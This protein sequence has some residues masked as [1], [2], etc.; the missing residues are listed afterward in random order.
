MHNTNVLLTITSMKRS[1]TAILVIVI[2]GVCLLCAGCTT[3]NTPAEVQDKVYIVGIDVPYPPFSMIDESG[4]ATGFDVE[5][6]RWIAKD[7]GLNLEFQQIAWDGIIPALLAGKID[8]VYSG[9]TITDERKEKVVFSDVY[10]I[11]QQA[12]VVP[13][14]SAMTM[15]DISSG[16]AIIGTQ[17]GC[18]AEIWI[19]DNLIATGKMPAENLKL[20]DNTPVAVGDL[21]SGRIDAVMYD[22]TVMADIIEGLPVQIIGYIETNEEFGIAI[23]PED[24]ELLTK[25]NAGLANLMASDDWQDLIKKYKMQ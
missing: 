25:I 9:M 14:D 4:E 1:I 8:M 20:Y 10:W 7:Q 19:E 6:A 15:D 3:T 23:R 17:R 22:S 21:T 13:D 24:T 12:V 16:K 5:S 2:A 11:V 18:T